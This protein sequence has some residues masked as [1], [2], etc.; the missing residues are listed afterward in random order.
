MSVLQTLRT[1]LPPPHYLQLPS[2]GVDVSDT[3]L[4]F[5]QFRPNSGH[6]GTF[7][8]VQFGDIPIEPGTLVR[9]EVKDM[10]K[11][12]AAIVEVK[13]RT[14]AAYI[15]LSLPEERAYLFET[16]LKKGTPFSEIRGLLEFRLEENVPLSPRDA[17]F[18]YEVYEYPGKSDQLGV[19]VTVYACDTING[20]YDACKQAGVTPLAL[21]V[22]AQAIARAV[23]PACSRQGTQMIVDCG[24]TRTGVGIVHNGILMYTSTIDIGGK[25]LSSAMRKELGEKEEGELTRLKNTG[26]L[27]RNKENAAVHAALIGTVS[28]IKD[29]VARRIQYWNTRG[30][31]GDDRFIE[32]IIL[33]GG[34]S[35]LKGLPEY[36]AESLGI[37][38][39]RAN[40]WQNAFDPHEVVPP[41]DQPHAYGYATAVGLGLA[42]LI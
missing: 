19:S 4:K 21:E 5:I 15:R 29:E 30:I 41:I 18:D 33:C 22:E 13:K 32:Q 24:R 31:G 12:V 9:G 37:E 8:I 11:L 27:S 6:A 26:G 23:L 20:Y 40:V 14:K 39:I 17:Y 36:F 3:S 28:A 16:E 35:N 42:N 38:T 1:F 34:S 2:V 7:S 10:K 25:E